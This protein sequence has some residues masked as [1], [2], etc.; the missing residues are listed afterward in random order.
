MSL[1]T[2]LYIRHLG[3]CPHK[4]DRNYRRC[5]CPVWFQ[6]NRRRWSADTNDWSEALKQAAAIVFGGGSQGSLQR[7]LYAHAGIEVGSKPAGMIYGAGL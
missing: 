6:R 5:G 4:K 2:T 3:K 1:A 7:P